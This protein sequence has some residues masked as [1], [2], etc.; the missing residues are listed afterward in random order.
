MLITFESGKSA[1]SCVRAPAGKDQA[2]SNIFPCETRV[3][4][5]D[6][7]WRQDLLALLKGLLILPAQVQITAVAV[8]VLHLYTPRSGAYTYTHIPSLVMNERR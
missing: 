1:P 4:V 7:R 2:R 5:C 8:D 6:Q 3:L